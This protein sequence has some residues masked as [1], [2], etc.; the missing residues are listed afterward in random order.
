MKYDCL[1]DWHFY[2][3]Y[4]IFPNEINCHSTGL[5]D[6]DIDLRKCSITILQAAVSGSMNHMILN[7]KL[8]SIIKVHN[9]ISP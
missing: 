1:L 8:K 4:N 2:S 5:A 6:V 7:L 9:T 3:K